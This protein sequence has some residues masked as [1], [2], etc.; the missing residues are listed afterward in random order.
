VGVSRFTTKYFVFK[1]CL[2]NAKSDM[3]L[4]AWNPPAEWGKYVIFADPFLELTG[5]S[6]L[7]FWYLL[8]LNLWDFILKDERNNKEYNYSE[9]SKKLN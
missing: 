8:L 1:N 2:P 7:M 6:R 4:S 3:I 9:L 5:A